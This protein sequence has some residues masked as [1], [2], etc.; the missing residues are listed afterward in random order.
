[1]ATIQ[2]YELLAVAAVLTAVVVVVLLFT[3]R[4]LK[5]RKAELLG[6]IRAN[7]RLNSDRAFN[8]IEMAR[9]EAAILARQGSDTGR[10]RSLIAQAQSAF[11]LGQMDRAYELAQSAHESLVA[12]R[13]G[14]ALPAATAPPI[15]STSPR[16]T[17]RP[18]PS[19][20]GRLAGATPFAG[21]TTAPPA[22]STGLPR[23]RVESQFEI[24]LLN[25]DLMTARQSRPTDPATVV[26]ADFQGK[27]EKAFAAGQYTEAFSFALKGRRGLGGNLGTVAPAP[28]AKPLLGEPTA[29]DPD[30][31]ADRA[32][33]ATRCP[34]CGYPTTP[35]DAFCRGCGTPRTAATCPR[36]G[37]PRTAADTFC[38][39]CGERFS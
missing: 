38:G 1:V 2:V 27:A 29:M 12:V 36:C 34:H 15:E 16:P 7:P 18:P 5:Q 37:T 4:R 39:R 11:D 19:E 22:A 17:S 32:A 14:Q 3:I 26:A 23:N 13:H 20:G 6:E 30:Q 25:S 24:K 28:G 10:P 21:T 35:D 33:S 31:V 8:R 9:R